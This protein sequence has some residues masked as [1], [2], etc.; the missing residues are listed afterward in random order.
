MTQDFVPD[1]FV[2]MP[3]AKHDSLV[4]RL[5]EYQAERDEARRWARQ[6]RAWYHQGVAR[7]IAQQNLDYDTIRWLKDDNND[8]RAKLRAAMFALGHSVTG[9]DKPIDAPRNYA[10]D[11]AYAMLK[12]RGAENATLKLEVNTITKN[13]RGF[14]DDYTRRYEYALK[15]IQKLQSENATLRAEVERLKAQQP[16]E[17]PG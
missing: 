10:A 12:E 8:L 4:S 11:D 1:W 2:S 16:Q 3:R 14:M 15:D 13:I 7:W 17:G 9:I 6:F 5:Q